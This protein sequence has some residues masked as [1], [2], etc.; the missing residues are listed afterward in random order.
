[1]WLDRGWPASDGGKWL[2]YMDGQN[3]GNNNVLRRINVDTRQ[4]EFVVRFN[5][6][7][8]AGF[9]LSLDATPHS[10]TYV[11]RTDNYVIAIYDMA[12]GDGDIRRTFVRPTNTFGLRLKARIASCSSP[13]AALIVLD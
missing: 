2:Y 9:A 11:K 4:D 3:G 10:G 6:S 1:M 13:D 7:A 12:R 5:R 8:A